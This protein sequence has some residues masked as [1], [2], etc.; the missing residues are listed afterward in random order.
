MTLTEFKR[1]TLSRLSKFVIVLTFSATTLTPALGQSAASGPDRESLGAEAASSAER[2]RSPLPQRKWMTVP[3]VAGRL[4]AADLG[5]VIN[6]ADPY[7]VQVGEHYARQRG[8]AED[9]ILRVNIPATAEMELAEFRA[10]SR[11]VDEFFGD[12][13]QALALAWRRPYAVECNSITGALSLGFD[14]ELCKNTCGRSKASRYFGS[15]SSRPWADH[16]MR[17]TMLLAA[18]TVE[19]AKALVDRG[20]KADGSISLRGGTPAHLHFVTTS[21]SVRS[22]RQTFFPPAGPIPGTGLVVHLDQTDALRNVQGVLMYVTGRTHVEHLDTVS[23]L[24]GALA[25]HLT[26]FG[27]VLDRQMGQMNILS[28]MEWGAT[29]SYGTTSEPCSHWQKF[30]HPQAL[31][32]FYTQGLTAIETYWKSVAWPQQGLF[33]GEPL[34]APF[35][36]VPLLR[37]PLKFGVLPG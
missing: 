28:W 15:S 34:A 2:L 22:V 18:P 20:V 16:R 31:V 3:R 4:T 23:F 7:S 9:Q 13:V 1:L 8:I 5:L 25:D 14:G 37:T 6:A 21:D 26:S 19:G 36:A 10:F 30:P 29:A 11:R 24:P 32:M 12:R 35:A 27:G 33:I 17:L